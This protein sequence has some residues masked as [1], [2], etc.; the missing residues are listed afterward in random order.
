FDYIITAEQVRSYKPVFDNFDFAIRK[1]GVSPDKILHVAQ[2]I[3]HDIV[4]AKTVGLSTVW[5]N[6]RKG[7]K[8]FGAT[9]PASGQADLE[10][11]GLKELVQI[12]DL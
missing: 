11:S 8:G 1:I 9:P 5:V 4:P 6:R 12:L 3:Y 10:V 7:K 2:S